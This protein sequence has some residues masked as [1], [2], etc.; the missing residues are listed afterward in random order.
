M[1]KKF[2]V[3]SEK[4][5]KHYEVKFDGGSVVIDGQTIDEE[6][7]FGTCLGKKL[8]PEKEFQYFDGLSGEYEDEGQ[9]FPLVVKYNPGDCTVEFEVG[10]CFYALPILY[11][12]QERELLQEFQEL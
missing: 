4:D 5:A 6:G 9:Y 7:V 8:L 10:A 1:K 11:E 12:G 3:A 2:Y